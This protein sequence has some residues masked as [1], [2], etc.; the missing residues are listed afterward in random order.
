MTDFLLRR[1]MWFQDDRERKTVDQTFLTADARSLVV[2][3]EA[4]M[5][6]STLLGQL[7]DLEGYIFCTARLLINAPDAATRFGGAE[8]LVVDALDE[9]SAQRDGDAVDLV[10]R[11]LAEL[12]YPRFILSCRVADWRSATGIQGLSDLYGQAPLELY[13]DPLEREDAVEV[14]SEALGETKAEEAASSLEE[15]G[16]AGLWSNPQTLNLIR[17]VIGRSALPRSRGDLFEAATNLMRKE[18]RDVKVDAKLMA[19]PEGAVLDAAGAA[20]ATLI[21]TGKDALAVRVNAG[22]D[23]LPLTEIA[24]LPHAA[25]IADVLDSRLFVAVESDRFSYAH[26]AIGEFLGARWLARCADT[27]RKRRRLLSLFNAPGLV[28]ASLRGLHAWLAWHSPELAGDVI[29][30]DPMGVI[31]YGDADELTV[32]QASGLLDAL[33]ALAEQNPRFRDWSEYRLAGLAQPALLTRLSA[34][35]ASSD[36]EFGLRLLILQAVKGSALVSALSNILDSLIRDQ[37]AAFA[38]RSAS[39]DRLFE[40][41]QA[42]DWQALVEELLRQGDEDAVRLGVEILGTVGYDIFSDD[43]IGRVVTAQLNRADRTIGGLY[44]L[45]SRLPL[46]RIGALLDALA[47]MDLQVDDDDLHERRSHFADLAQALLARLLPMEAVAPDRLWGWLQ[48]LDAHHGYQREARELVANHLRSNDALR[49]AIQRRV[50]IDEVPKGNPWHAGWRLGERS[51]GLLPDE[52][53]VIALLGVMETNDARWRDILTISRHDAEQGGAARRAAERFTHGDPEAEAW[54]A[55]LGKPETPQWEI[56]Q[57]RRK[58][59]RE[60]ERVTRWKKH[61]A[62]F[63]RQV[64]ELRSGAFRLVANPARAYLKLFADMGDKDSD[65]AGRLEEWL[66]AGLRDAALAGIEAFLTADPVQPSAIEIAESHADNKHWEAAYIIVAA[67]AERYRTGRGFADLPTERVMAGFVEVRSN[68]IDDHAGVPGL[69]SALAEELRKRGVWE[70]ALRLYFEPQFRRGRAHVDGLYALMREAVDARLATTL[71]LEWLNRF[72]AM[73]VGPEAELVD[74]LLAVPDA[75][76]AL[77]DL[78]RQRRH[79][80]SLEPERRL[81]WDTVGLLVDFDATRAEMEATGSVPDDLLW[82]VRSRLG[83]RGAEG[84]RV[85]V[86]PDQALWMLRQFRPSFP[87]TYRPSGVTSGDANAWDASDFVSA[88]IRR[89]GDNTSEAAVRA[90]KDLRDDPADPYSELIRTA[91]AEQKRKRVEADWRAPEFSTVR[92]TVQDAAPTTSAQLQSVLLEELFKVQALLR[93]SDLDWY[94]DF[95]TDGVPHGEER[96]RDSLL[97]MLRPLPF[98]IDAIPEAHLAD[99]KRADVFCQLGDLGVPIEIKGQWHRELWSAADDQLNRLYVNDWRA[100]VGIYLVF[101]FGAASSKKLQA[102]PA[103]TPTPT[104]APELQ[105][106][107]TETSALAQEGR[108]AVVVLDLER[109]S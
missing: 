101:W 3:G 16:L 46:D 99:D 92:A 102:P 4:G 104:S 105:A 75:L 45:Q 93:G 32:S 33:E 25:A 82:H 66:G 58:R 22:D 40:M 73:A 38:L 50:L 19:Q 64:E 80:S 8:T 107:L 106:A 53:D 7:R 65:G 30:A 84:G 39:I 5:G 28:P 62:E 69:A 79:L 44:H 61:R 70:E 90:L 74:H 98:G 85:D 88:L 47:S 13:L 9:I 15:Q 72:E 60:T 29:A 95:V 54:L 49:R 12:G 109:P 36:V 20:F 23:D 2:L 97:K 6:K 81:I 100:E 51:P 86:E 43:L 96:C 10:V 34:L 27:V 14:L 52:G 24:T 59:A 48:T 63:E 56:D 83:S 89:L 37:T 71:A 35:I 67:L 108:I 103:G 17:E 77:R 31:Q 76:P 1:T 26:R 42:R 78:A 41:D 87:M 91:L 21:L 11:K 55:K 18:H 68:R 94:R 57:N